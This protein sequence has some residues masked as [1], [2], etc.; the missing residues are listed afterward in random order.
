VAG[1]TMAWMAWR[2]AR[3]MATLGD[4][5]LFYQA[6]SR[7]QGFMRALLSSAGQV[8]SN[9]LFLGN[10]FAF[11]DL[12]PAIT[13]PPL[14]RP[15][16]ERL[17]RGISFDGVTFTYPG[18]DRPALENFSLS[19]PNGTIAAIVGPNGAGK[20]T[21]LKLLSRFY[22]PAS[23]RVTID[24]IDIRVFSVSDLRR[25]LTVLF[26]VPLNYCASAAE[27][28]ALGGAMGLHDKYAVQDAAARAGAHDFISRLPF[29][30]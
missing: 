17:S 19:I 7:G 3:G 23:G 5:A 18:A 4:L 6:F 8:Y 16:P 12:K 11:L 9:T 27:S 10:L 22:D 2:T 25:I 24:G 1:L 14:P 30:Y 28:I 29:G 26:Q 21:L 15:V 13:S 20:T